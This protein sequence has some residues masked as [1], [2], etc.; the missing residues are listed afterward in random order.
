MRDYTI[1]NSSLSALPGLLGP[2]VMDTWSN[3]I[4]Y[5]NIQLEGNVIMQ[6]GINGTTTTPSLFI[7]L[8]RSINTTINP[9]FAWIQK[10]GHYIINQTYVRIDDQVIDT[11]YGEWLEIWH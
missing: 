4:N 2:H 9:N 6:A 11:Q 5:Y 8:E 1:Q 3:I 10:I 7:V